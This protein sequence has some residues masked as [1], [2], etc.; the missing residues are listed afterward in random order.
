[1]KNYK[2]ILRFVLIFSVTYI[3]L[4]LPQTGADIQYEKFFRK[5]GNQLFGTI[6]TE[7]VL[8]I[9][10]ESGD[11][12]DTRIYL[13]AKKL[14][15]KNNDYQSEIFPI[16]A[17]R[18]GFISTAFFFS[19]VLATPL[20]WKRKLF[21]MLIGLSL[22]TLYAM[23]KLRVLILHFYT[24][25][26]TTGLYQLP[27]QKKSIEFWSDYFARP[28]TPV[29]YY[30]LVV[31]LAVCFNKQDFQKLNGTFVKLTTKQPAQQQTAKQT[32]SSI[33]SSSKK[34]K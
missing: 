32:L 34:K 12:Y 24:L 18:I 11:G 23:L 2:V 22:V 14:L 3:I 16:N 27:E 19:L 26:K 5:L 28:N 17:R 1:M 10:E 6:G 8:M 31:W 29:Y 9:R 15:Q 7:G 4:L 33:K 21:A 25:T 13:S 30:V 20:S